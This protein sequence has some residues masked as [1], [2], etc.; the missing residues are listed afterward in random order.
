MSSHDARFEDSPAYDDRG[1]T[2][3]TEQPAVNRTGTTDDPTVDGTPVQLPEDSGPEP[4]PDGRDTAGDSAPV[5]IVDGDHSSV[6]TSGDSADRRT[7]D[8]EVRTEDG[9][10]RTE[11]GDLRTEDGESRTDDGLSSRTG[12]SELSV[13]PDTETGALKDPVPDG[14]FSTDAAAS[15]ASAS[16]SGLDSDWRDLQGRFVD[17]PEGTVRE[18][19]ALV[20][21]ALSELRTRTE[22]G[23]TE[24]LRTAF[25]R[26]RDL[27][28]NLS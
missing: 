19:G 8:G 3:R 20:E 1:T 10:L 2:T 15:A 13:G 28:T 12:S 11:D 17:D 27:Y 24:D 16:V 7:E 21:K 23:S 25:R 9:D 22:S 14:T 26:Y 5:T 6:F 18:A 4:T